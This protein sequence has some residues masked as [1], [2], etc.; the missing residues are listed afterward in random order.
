[1]QNREDAPPPRSRSISRQTNWSSSRHLPVAYSPLAAVDVNGP[2]DGSPNGPPAESRE[3]A[4]VKPPPVEYD[5][6]YG[7]A[8]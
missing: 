4:R 3:H 2:A 6:Q 1:M 5:S 8:V 7:Y